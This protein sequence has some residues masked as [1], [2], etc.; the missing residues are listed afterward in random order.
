[1][2]KVVNI[3]AI[4]I[5]GPFALLGSVISSTSSP[6]IPE[7]AYRAN[8]NLHGLSKTGIQVEK[9][10]QKHIDQAT[11]TGMPTRHKRTQLLA[12]A[13]RDAEKSRNHWHVKK[14]K[15][16]EKLQKAGRGK[17]TKLGS[18]LKRIPGSLESKHQHA[19]KMRNE[20]MQKLIDIASDSKIHER[21]GHFN[22][23]DRQLIRKV[24]FPESRELGYITPEASPPRGLSRGSDLR[25]EDLPP[26]P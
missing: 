17:D 24:R 25:V 22:S 9:D 11:R 10:L 12:Q 2:V 18:V 13:A 15:L 8:P 14:I 21:Q 5:V 4:I 23:N 3:S 1:M 19:T 20:E 16:D 6:G 26:S 7:S